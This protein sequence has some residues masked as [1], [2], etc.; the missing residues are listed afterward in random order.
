MILFSKPIDI[1]KDNLGQKNLFCSGL[2]KQDMPDQWNIRI[3]GFNSNIKVYREQK[4]NILFNSTPNTRLQIH[5]FPE[6]SSFHE[7]M[8]KYQNEK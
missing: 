5:F 7:M 2:Q 8:L 4:I 6:S 1:L 3:E